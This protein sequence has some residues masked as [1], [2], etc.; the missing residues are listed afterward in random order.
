MKK[1]PIVVNR[2]KNTYVPHFMCASIS[3]VT[4]PIM[5][6]FYGWFSTGILYIFGRGS[7]HPVCEREGILVEIITSLRNAEVTYWS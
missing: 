3:G 6:L 5:K 7:H 1:A 4:W 2:P